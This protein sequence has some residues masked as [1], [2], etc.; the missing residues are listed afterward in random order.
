M[1]AAILAA[2]HGER[3]Q[4]PGVALP[5]PLVRVAG[6]TLIEHTL[7]SVR[8]AGARD[9]ACIVNLDAAEVE[10]YC[11]ARSA[12][13]ELRF[14]HRTTASSM[15]SLFAL[16]PLL[17]GAPFLL[18]TVDTIIAP[19]AVRAFVTAAGARLERAADGVL[20]V[21]EFVDDEKPLRVACDGAGR[22]V[23]LGDTAAGS[24][25]VTAGL[26]VFAPRI[27]AEIDAARAAGYGALR[28][29]LAHLVARGYRLE[30]ELVPK[31]VDVDRPEDLATA[32]AF[33]ASGYAA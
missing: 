2:G 16:A 21:T 18:L 28:A 8:A 20:A 13:L 24:A 31:C 23:H 33:I 7:G 19:D 22:I 29:F 15:E 17:A 11:R 12:G 30:T 32:E 6:K 4:R 3:L 25:R 9:V 10:P 14:L 27:F 1:N 5:K 26:Y